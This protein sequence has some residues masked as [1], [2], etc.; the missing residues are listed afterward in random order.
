MFYFKNFKNVP[1]LGHYLT[2]SNAYKKKTSKKSIHCY[3]NLWTKPHYNKLP[4]N[5]VKKLAQKKYNEKL[6][7]GIGIVGP[8]PIRNEASPVE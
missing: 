7:Y 8:I 2:L 6:Y 4:I 1:T 3:K 5:G